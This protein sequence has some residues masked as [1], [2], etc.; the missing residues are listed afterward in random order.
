MGDLAVVYTAFDFEGIAA[1][2]AVVDEDLIGDGEVEGD[3]EDLPAVG[4]GYGV[5]FLHD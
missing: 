3:V 4:A 2:F 1:D 5:G